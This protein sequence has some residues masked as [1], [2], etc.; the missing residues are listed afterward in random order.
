MR[1]SCT[2]NAPF[3]SH[4]DTEGILLVDAANAFNL[5]R[6]A[7]LHNMKFLSLAT[8]LTNTYQSPTRMLVSGGGEVLSSEG[9]TQGDP[10]GMGMYALAV[11]PLIN[12]LQELHGNTR[13]VWFADDAICQRLRAW[14]DELVAR[15]P[16][17]GYYPKA[18]KTFLVVKEE[19]AEE[20]ERAF[21]YTSVSITTQGKRHLGAAVGSMTFRDEFVSGKVKSWCK[22]AELLSQVALS[23]PH[24]A[25]AAYIH[26]QASKWTYIS[27]TIPGIGHL[28][29]PL[30]QVIQEKFIPAIT[31]GR[32]SCSKIEHSLLSLP[33]RMGG[34]GLTIPSADAEHCYEASSKITAPIAAMIALRGKDPM[35]AS[36]ESKTIGSSVRNVKRDNQRAEAEAIFNE[37]PPPQQRVLECTREKGASAWLSALPVDEH[38]FY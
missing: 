6:K 32:P 10:L 13:Q 16:S 28:L 20:A 12:K 3:F 4:E 14:W 9:T 36:L 27:R 23:H 17:F 18:S 2:C 26:G 11:I 5:N 30:E 19:Y 8:I 24:A 33:A 35:S 21:A 22:E 31:T 37:L 15:G 1:G 7:A 34:L 25:F 29:E 38:G